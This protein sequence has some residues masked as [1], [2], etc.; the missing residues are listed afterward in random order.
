MDCDTDCAQSVEKKTATTGVKREESVT[1]LIQGKEKP[2]RAQRMSAEDASACAL[3]SV[4]AT[5]AVRGL[6]FTVRNE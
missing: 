1:L 6:T 4:G 3:G 5:S 2:Q